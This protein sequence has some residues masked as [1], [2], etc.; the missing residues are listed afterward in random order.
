[1]SHSVSKCLQTALTIA[2][3]CD[4]NNNTVFTTSHSVVA[5]SGEWRAYEE[6]AGMVCLQYK[7]CVIIPER[8]SDEF[9]TMWRYTNVCIFT[10]IGV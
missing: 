9:L 6:K 8:F 1:M 5:P 4:N 2:P 7:N 10:F 3:T